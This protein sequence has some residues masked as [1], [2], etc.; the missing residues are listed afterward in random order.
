MKSK[1]QFLE[2]NQLPVSNRTLTVGDSIM[3]SDNLDMSDPIDILVASGLNKKINKPFKIKFSMLLLCMGGEMNISLNLK[4]FTLQPQKLI[5]IPE[6]TIGDKVTLSSDLQLIMIAFSNAPRI[7]YSNIKPSGDIISAL[8]SGPILSLTETETMTVKSIY[9]I[10]RSRL[11]QPGF[12]AAR[13]LTVN[14]IR[15][16]FSYVFPHLFENRPLNTDNSLLDSFLRLIEKHALKNRS[17]HFYA[18]KLSVTPRHL[19]RVILRTSGKPIKQWI[20]ERIILEA[21]VL[22]NEPQL[23]VQQISDTLGFPNQSAFGTYF[24]K[25]TSLSPLTYR[26]LT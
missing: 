21:K 1:N 2:F 6:G 23:T 20:R 19:S 7:L 4:Q 17:I 25:S 8:N 22:L 26:K 15:L 11:T 16:I 10:M 5:L 12:P 14:A 13:E 18:D 3:I 24:K 9:D